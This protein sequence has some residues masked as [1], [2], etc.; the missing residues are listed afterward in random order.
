MRDQGT[1][2]LRT[3]K[4]L[5]VDHSF[6]GGHPWREKQFTPLLLSVAKISSIGSRFRECVPKPLAAYIAREHRLVAD[7]SWEWAS[8]HWFTTPC[9]VLMFYTNFF[10]ASTPKVSQ[11]PQQMTAN[12]FRLCI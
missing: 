8:M 1:R 7:R 11:A 2:K 6:M 10:Q 4:H 12:G 3:A 9:T 5:S